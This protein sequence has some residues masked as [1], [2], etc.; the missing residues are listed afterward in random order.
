MP[1]QKQIIEAIAEILALPVTDID[2]ESNLKDDL[3]LNR[4]EIADLFNGLSQKF[5]IIF[6]SSEVEDL[7]SIG[8]LVD[9]VED[10]LLE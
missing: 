10:K 6:D 3:G 2:L 7:A 4:V 1:E 8:D 9:L 5:N